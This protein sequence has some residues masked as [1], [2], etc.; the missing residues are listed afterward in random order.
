MKASI[1]GL[2]V[3]MF[4]AMP[5]ASMPIASMRDTITNGC[6]LSTGQPRD[7]KWPAHDRAFVSITSA[8]AGLET[9]P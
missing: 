2:W 4:W 8:T 3:A 9:I 1:S 6:V 5:E 7:L